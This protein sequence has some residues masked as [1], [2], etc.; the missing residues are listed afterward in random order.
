VSNLVKKIKPSKRGELEITD[1]NN[2]FLQQS[3]MKIRFLDGKVSWFDAGTYD[4][5]FKASQKIYNLSAIQ[6]RNLSNLKYLSKKL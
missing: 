4:N 6:R 5:L 1:L 3:K 2:E